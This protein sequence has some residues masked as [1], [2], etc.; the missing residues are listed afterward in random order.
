M[1]PEYYLLIGM[2]QTSSLIQ[3]LLTS[4][5]LAHVIPTVMKS[6]IHVAN[7]SYLDS[8]FA[9]NDPY[10]CGIGCITFDKATKSSTVNNT[11]HLQLAFTMENP[12]A[13]I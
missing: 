6:L 5:C 12:N 7:V 4:S 3:L 2:K 11:N 9:H 13:G 1:V 10:T 8:W